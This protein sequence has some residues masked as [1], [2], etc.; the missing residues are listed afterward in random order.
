VGGFQAEKERNGTKQHDADQRE[1]AKETENEEAQVQ[2][3]NATN[4]ESE[5]KVGKDLSRVVEFITRH[6]LDSFGSHG[7]ERSRLYWFPKHR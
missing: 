6:A 7:I 1:K 4:E 5:K 3:A 2:E